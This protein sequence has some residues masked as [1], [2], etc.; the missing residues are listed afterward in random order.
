MLIPMMET[1]MA[2]RSIFAAT[3]LLLTTACGS[4]PEPEQGKVA[5][6]AVSGDTAAGGTATQRLNPGLWQQKG[7]LANAAGPAESRCVSPEDALTANGSDAQIRKALGKQAAKDGCT[8]GSI[9]ID[10]PT[11]AWTQT[12]SGTTLSMSTDYRGDSSTTTMSG[13]GIPTMTTESVRIG[14]C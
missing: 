2:S 4:A 13:G 12:C 10:G 3:F 7:A 14:D 11:I 8:I 5:G 1:D 9:N 6:Q